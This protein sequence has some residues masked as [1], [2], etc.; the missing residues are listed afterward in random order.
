MA[1]LHPSGLSLFLAVVWT[2]LPWPSTFRFRTPSATGRIQGAVLLSPALSARKPRI[3]LY[4]DYGPGSAPIPR[5]PAMDEFANVVIYLDSVATAGGP[6]NGAAVRL[7]VEQR[8]ETF[9]PHVLPVLRGSTVEFPNKDPVFHNVFSLSSSRSFDL[10]RYPKGTSKSVRF[11]RPGTVQVFC[12]IHSDMSAV[13]LV[14][15]NPFF[16]IPA[17]PGRYAI[18]GVP[19]GEYRLVAWHERIKPIVR[20]VRVRAGETTILDLN[21]PVPP[22]TDAQ[23]R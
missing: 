17:A 1:V 18:D 4:G 13:V 5:K 11:D 21:V 3:R 23:G 20:S 6:G 16:T 12:H 22:L 7:V 2:A 10:G 9:V 8:D 14:L 19:A 15:D